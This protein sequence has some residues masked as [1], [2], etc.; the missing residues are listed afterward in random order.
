M[1]ILSA[2]LS[3]GLGF[4][5]LAQESATRDALFAKSVQEMFPKLVEFGVTFMCIPA[6]E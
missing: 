2:A 5:A 3:L 6:V 4:S 1:K